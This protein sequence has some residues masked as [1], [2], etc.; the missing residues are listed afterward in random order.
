MLFV[1]GLAVSVLLRQ[2]NG[3]PLSGVLGPI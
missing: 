2:E 1:D 3:G